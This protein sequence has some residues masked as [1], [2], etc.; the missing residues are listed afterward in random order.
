MA[1]EKNNNLKVNVWDIGPVRPDPPE[2]PVAPKEGKGHDYDLSMIRYE[3]AMVDYRAALRVYGDQLKAH[4]DWGTRYGG[5]ILH[6][7]WT[8]DADDSLANDPSRY[9]K[10]LPKGMKPGKGYDEAQRQK[11][12]RDAEIAEAERRDPQFGQS[13]AGAPA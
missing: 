2:A 3:D 5:P 7:M 13:A 12:A 9:F 6:E 4:R 11:Q 8:V 1:N 10:T